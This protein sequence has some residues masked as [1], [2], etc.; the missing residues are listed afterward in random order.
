MLRD[1]ANE[2][3]FLLGIEPA[4]IHDQQQVF[5]AFLPVGQP[6]A[7]ARSGKKVVELEEGARLI[8]VLRGMDPKDLDF[9]QEVEVELEPAGEESA[10]V[11]LVPARS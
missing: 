11:W 10:F 7:A 3:R 5:V 9:D 2:I 8:G 6:V 1:E 4:R